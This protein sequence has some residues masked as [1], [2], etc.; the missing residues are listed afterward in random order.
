MMQEKQEKPEKF[1]QVTESS[2]LLP[3]LLAK[4]PDT[5]RNKVKGILTRGQV[6]VEGKVITKHDH[7][8]VA[9]Q[10]VRINFFKP[11]ST[12]GLHGLRIVYEDPY[13][14][15][16]EKA[17]GLLSIATD[18]EK[19]DT[20]YRQL[21]DYL[22]QGHSKQRIYILHRL[23]RDTSGLMLFAKSIDVQ[24]T[25]QE[26]WKDYVS[27]RVYTVLVEGLVEKDQDTVTSWLKETKTM[28]MYS[29]HTPGDG[30]LAVTHYRVLRRGLHHTLIEARLETGRKNQIRV[31]MK[32]IGHL[33]VGDKRYG[34]KGNPI[35][36][37][38]LHARVLE[39]RHPISNDSM[40]FET[41]VPAAFLQLLDHLPRQEK[42]RMKRAK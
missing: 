18:E 35:G 24:K 8:L 22:E 17:A 31:H 4:M 20:A 33:V 2:T 25:M 41:E 16:V 15:V 13:L 38:G 30:D 29:S 10:V 36:R 37:L 9:G 40:L 26:N 1:W 34:A 6:M 21:Q 5:G 11:L 12:E 3:F 7:A 19:H 23:D 27:E 14:L 28:L 32:D 39:F 42:R